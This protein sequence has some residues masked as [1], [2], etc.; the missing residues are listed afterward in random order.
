[1]V[2]VLFQAAVL[3]FN[4]AFKKSDGKGGINMTDTVIDGIFLLDLLLQF[5]VAIQCPDNAAAFVVDR[6]KIAESYLKGW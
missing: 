2:L 5:N 3:P 6:K 4:L 1:M